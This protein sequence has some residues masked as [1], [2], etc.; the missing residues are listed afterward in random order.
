MTAQFFFFFFRYI[1]GDVIV[2]KTFWLP[3]SSMPFQDLEIIF[4]SVVD[5]DIFISIVT[6]ILLPFSSTRFQDL[7]IIFVGVVDV[8]IFV[9]VVV[10][11]SLPFSS[12][13]FQDLKII[14]VGVVGVVDVGIFISVVVA[15]VAEAVIRGTSERSEK[16]FV[17]SFVAL[18][19]S[20][21]GDR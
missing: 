8:G 11:S 14:F 19:L 7:E 10:V 20:K 15:I 21:P 9:G 13:P 16:F 17:I 12:T 6:V 1:I 5:V 3:F 18:V 2:S 4:V